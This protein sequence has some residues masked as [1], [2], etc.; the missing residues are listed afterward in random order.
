MAAQISA[1]EAEVRAHKRSST[2]RGERTRQLHH[3]R[4]SDPNQAALPAP[5]V[6]IVP[7]GALS[8][9]RSHRSTAGLLFVDG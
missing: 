1:P 5:A 6:P 9:A 2:A 3:L 4:T 8:R 7:D